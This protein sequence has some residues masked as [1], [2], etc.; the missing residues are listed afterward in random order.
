MYMKKVILLIAA[1][2]ITSGFSLYAQKKEKINDSNSPLHLLQ[3]AYKVPYGELSTGAI[4]KDL[5][6]ILSYLETETPARVIDK[7]TQ[8]TITDYSK[9]DEN[10]QLDKGAFR[11]ASYEWGVTYAAML[12]AG[13]ATGDSRFTDYV[14]NRFRFLSEVAPSFK[15]VLENTGSTD[16]QMRQI[17]APHALDDAGAMCAAMIKASRLNP[18]LQLNSLVNNYM[19]YIMYHEYRLSDGTFARNRPQKNTLWLDDMFMS[20]PAIAQM[21]KL[22]GEDKYYNEAVKQILQFSSRMFVK[23]KGLYRHGWV[24]G[25]KQHPSFH[26]ARANGWALLTLVETLDVLPQSHP[27]YDVI[28]EQLQAHIAGLAACQSG[29]GFWHQLLDRNDSY[30]ETSATAIYVYCI[31]HAINRGWVDAV[32]Y[33]PVA[34]LG[35]H[36]ISTKI[37]AQGEVEGTCV[38]TGMGFDPAYY[39]YRPVNTFAAHGYG[40]VIWAGAEMIKLLNSQYP[41]MNDSAVQYYTTPQN[42]TSPIFS[43]DANVG[44]PETIIAGSSRKTEKAPVVF[45]IGDS[46]AKNGQG[47]GDGDMWGW[48]AFLD[49]FFDTNK[50]TVE[51]HALGGMSSRTFLTAGLWEKVL[52]G[53]KKGDYLIIQFGH[54]DG[55]PLNT[56]RARASLNGTGEESQTVIMERN[57]GPEDVFTFGHY[58]RL[59]IRQAK[60]HGAIPIVLSHTPGNR[61]T[62]SKMNRCDETYAKWSKEVAEQEG[63]FYI[64][65]NDRSARKFESLGIEKTKAFYKDNVHTT[66]DGAILNAKSV[67]EGLLDLPNCPLNQYINKTALSK[68]FRAADK[69]LFRDPVYD[70]AADPIVVW[71]KQEQKWFMFYTNRRANMTNSKGVDWVHGTPIGIAESTDGSSWK[72]R[73]TANIN[74]GSKDVTYWAPDIV[75]NNGIYHMFL[76]VVPGIFTDWKHEREIVHLTSSNLIDWKFASKLSLASDKVIDACIVKAPDGMWRM[77][78][79]NEKD[80]KSIYYAQSKDLNTWED[81]GKAVGD[82]AGE[83]PKI[84]AWKGKYFMIVDNWNGQAVYSSDDMENWRRQERNILKEPGKGVDDGTNGLHADVVVNNGNAYIFYFT[85]PG[86]VA[87]P[88]GKLDNYETRRSSV[89]VGKLEYENGEIKCDR[90]KP[91]YINL[92]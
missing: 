61:W 34:Q 63:V 68:D 6:R 90:D 87:T 72:Y 46:T 11:L 16:P 13:L 75:E 91:V 22:T 84:F 10:A 59:Y 73:G 89:Q 65:V 47:K 45:V 2:Q 43:A 83:G 74:Y 35:W 18:S 79:N 27:Q 56:G 25:M 49:N 67:V 55:G 80:H 69:P 24:E 64:D 50:I 44:R 36:A 39:C 31:A 52:S 71:N 28:M 8:K 29:E 60:A 21:G 9:I 81:K 7:N 14:Y 58:L 15:K 33:G 42:T 30:L 38:G 37:N 12:D 41:R 88:S 70:G 57:G 82:R 23:E 51:N 54:N 66:F 3:P 85:H 1:M 62:E 5:S 48:A 20:V 53:I 86:R 40:P 32:A 17:L 78:Y 76:T 26:W 92:R 77:Y 4:K 19:N